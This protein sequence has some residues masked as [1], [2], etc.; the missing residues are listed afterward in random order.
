MRSGHTSRGPVTEL[1]SF[2]THPP[3]I[4]GLSVCRSVDRK[5][6]RRCAGRKRIAQP[7]R[8]RS[9]SYQLF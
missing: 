3:P 7:A 5:S 8:E 4:V 9:V 2:V 1:G 6:S